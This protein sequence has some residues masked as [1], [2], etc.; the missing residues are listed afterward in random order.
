MC[1]KLYSSVPSSTKF[2]EDFVTTWLKTKYL[3]SDIT[4]QTL[5]F[6]YNTY[7]AM[8]S[9]L[10]HIYVNSYFELGCHKIVNNSCFIGITVVKFC[11]HTVN[12]IV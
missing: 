6:V 7:I 12:G 11:T 10:A 1:A 5:T 2:M 9:V 3:K 8:E 4:V